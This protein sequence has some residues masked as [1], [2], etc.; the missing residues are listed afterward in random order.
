LKERVENSGNIAPATENTHASHTAA[1]YLK[2]SSLQ[3]SH[4]KKTSLQTHYCEIV[5]YIGSIH[6]T[7]PFEK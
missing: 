1:N 6:Q 2:V 7:I 3:S 4:I 5:T